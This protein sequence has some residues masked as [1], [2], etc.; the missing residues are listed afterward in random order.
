M[1]DSLDHA[2]G[3]YES[4]GRHLY[5]LCKFTTEV[6]KLD[7]QYKALKGGIEAAEA[8]R[9]DLQREIE[10]K[11]A[12]LANLAQQRRQTDNELSALKSEISDK[13]TE[14]TALSSAL[15]QIQTMLEVGGD[16]PRL[17][18]GKGAFPLDE[19]INAK[20]M[21]ARLSRCVAIAAV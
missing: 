5:S 1:T 14:L 13:R 10:G 12:D 17:S 21:T 11:H 9:D 19:V 4:L 15:E 18:L 7:D 3:N 20:L 6:C 16:D 2:I 8:Q